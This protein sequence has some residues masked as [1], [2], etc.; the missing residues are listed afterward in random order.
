MNLNQVTYGNPT[1]QNKVFIEEN[2]LVD[3]LFTKLKEDFFP[4]NDSELVKDELNELV[5]YVNS[6]SDEENKA[7]L[8]R[9]KA[10]DRSLS[11]V[12]TTTFK[13]RGIDVETLCEDIIKDIRNLIFKLKYF[14]QRPRP[15][16]LAQYY[17]LKLFPYNSNSAST[18]SYPSGHTLE[19]CVILN[20]ISD[21]YP[22]EYQFCREMIDDIA[23]SRLYLGLHYPTDNDFAKEVAKEIL[24][25]PKF[26]K[27]YGI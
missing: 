9:Y 14:Y 23:Y 15:Y 4:P 6:I 21:K 12:I 16:Q 1:K 7:F 3:D 25:H 8:T 19:A 18:P 20:V 2:C 13:Q 11:Q 24:K 5:D 27:K 17:K 10:Y 26:T 22:N